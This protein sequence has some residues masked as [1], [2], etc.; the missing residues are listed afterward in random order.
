MASMLWGLGSM[1]VQEDTAASGQKIGSVSYSHPNSLG[2]DE[3]CNEV[4]G[5]VGYGP[6]GKGRLGLDAEES[7]QSLWGACGAIKGKAGEIRAMVKVR[8]A[9]LEEEVVAREKIL[10]AAQQHL[11]SYKDKTVFGGRHVRPED[12]MEL[13]ARRYQVLE[14]SHYLADMQQEYDQKFEEGFRAEAELQMGRGVIIA[15]V[16]GNKE[17]HLNGV[18]EPTGSAYNDKPLLRKHRRLNLTITT[19]QPQVI[20]GDEDAWLRFSLDG[21]WMVS[22][23]PNKDA[24]D[25]IAWCASEE[26]GIHHPTEVNSWKIYYNH[27]KAAWEKHPP[28]TCLVGEEKN[29]TNSRKK[30]EEDRITM[31]REDENTKNERIKDQVTSWYAQTVDKMKA[32]QGT[33]SSCLHEM[34]R[35]AAEGIALR[36]HLEAEAVKQNAAADVREPTEISPPNEW[37]EEYKRALLRDPAAAAAAAAEKRDQVKPSNE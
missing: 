19:C 13:T 23:T 16:V 33:Q 12:Q 30:E 31:V 14:A 11:E 5:L 25:T 8:L 28:M 3:R 2:G 36:S 27:N 22:S 10:E 7:F 17:K 15:G 1:G 18:Y 9:A 21:R 34:R 4:Y 20:D 26:K 6:V 32:C 35:R 29:V 24:N 37:V